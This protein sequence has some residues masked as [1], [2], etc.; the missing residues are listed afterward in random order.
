MLEKFKEFSLVSFNKKAA[1]ACSY[2]LHKLRYCLRPIR[3][4]I[5][6]RARGYADPDLW[7]LD[8]TIAKF[9]Y[10]RVKAFRDRYARSTH[11]EVPKI[12]TEEDIEFLPRDANGNCTLQT[13]SFKEWLSILDKIVFAFER[14][15]K[16]YDYQ[17]PLNGTEEEQQ[18]IEEG[19]Q[20]FVKHLH[21]LWD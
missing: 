17:D 8:T 4:F 6:R 20:L 16:K 1:S 10:P 12:L 9:I 21:Q 19:L 7:S 11:Y 15:T 2:L 18:A 5:Q 14:I 3:F 13:Y